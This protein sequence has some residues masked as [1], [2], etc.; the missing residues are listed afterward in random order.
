MV[1]M[2]SPLLLDLY[3]T[4]FLR[5]LLTF[6]HI[7][8]Q[9]NFAVLD[10]WRIFQ[11]LW[12][13][14]SAVGFVRRRQTSLPVADWE[15]ISLL[16]PSAIPPV[17]AQ[18]PVSPGS[19]SALPTTCRPLYLNSFKWE[20]GRRMVQRRDERMERKKKSC[21]PLRHSIHSQT[22]TLRHSEKNLELKWER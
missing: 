9:H 18:S 16:A 20:E 1:I 13:C 12:D 21:A 14:C 15:A 7:F 3:H 8:L 4:L 2:I 11:Q 17:A 5:M 10:P 19:F 22:L 6:F